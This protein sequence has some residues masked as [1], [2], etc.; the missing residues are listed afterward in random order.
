MEESWQE[1]GS[2][3]C[4]C[5]STPS[6]NSSLVVF[7]PKVP[8][9]AELQTGASRLPQDTRPLNLKDCS[10]KAVARAVNYKLKGIVAAWATSMQRGFVRGRSLVMNVPIIDAAA[11]SFAH[12]DPANLPCLVFVDFKAV[13][14]S[15]SW[16]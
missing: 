1:S 2:V 11:R 12:R 16:E 9:A 13:F 15:V 7:P 10:S 8:T 6:F 5:G 14:P 4:L 3:S